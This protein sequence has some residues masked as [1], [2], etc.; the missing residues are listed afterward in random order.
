MATVYEIEHVIA[1]ASQFTGAVPSL[2]SATFSALDAEGQRTFV[3]AAGDQTPGDAGGEF[4]FPFSAN[5]ILWKVDRVHLDVGAGATWILKVVRATGAEVEVG[6][7]TGTAAYIL[8]DVAT[9]GRGDKLVLTT[10]DATLEMRASVIARPI[11][12]VAA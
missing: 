1:A 9:L 4:D 2:S 8:N 12:T 5:A 6:T 7:S 11:I 10:T 3:D